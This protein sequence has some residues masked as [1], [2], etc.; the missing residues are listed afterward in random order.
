[1]ALSKT[2]NN[3]VYSIPQ[4]GE[5]GWATLT[6][7]LAALAD[8]AQTTNKQIVGRR[9]VTATPATVVATTDCYIGVN[10]LNA[11]SVVNLPAGVN[12]QVFIISDES[13]AAGTYNITITPNGLNTI[14]GGASFVLNQNKQTIYILYSG[15]NWVILH[16]S[17]DVSPISSVTDSS[18]ID[19]TVTAGV[20][21]ATIVAGSL[22]NADVNASAAIAYSKLN[23]AD[24]IVNADINS[25]AAIAYAKLNLAGGIVNADINAAAAIAYSKL[26]LAGSIVN[27]DI[28]ASAAIVYSKLSLTDS[29]L[30]ADI[31]SAAAIART[32]IANGT[33]DHVIINDGSGTLSSS[34][35]LASTK[36]GTG[37][38]NAGTLTYGSNN[39]TITT[40]GATTITSPTSGTLATLAGTEDLSNKSFTNATVIKAANELRF[41]NAA[42]TFYTAILA[43][44][45]AANRTIKLPITAPA[46]GNALV[47]TDTNGTLDWASPSSA[48][49]TTTTAGSITREGVWTAY[50]P[51]ITGFGTVTNLTVFWKIL[52]DSLMIRGFATTGT[53][54]AALASIT[55]PG[56][57]TMDTAKVRANASGASGFMV[58]HHGIQA[59]ADTSGYMVTATTTSS[60]VVYWAGA[61]NGVNSL[62]AQN[63]NALYGVSKDFSFQFEIPL[64]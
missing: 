34:A 45:N 14:N 53:P 38:N 2:W 56:G 44:N 12:G 26:N 61:I 27:A 22:V 21:T 20:L 33:A 24:S 36:G 58:G 17:T 35:Q 47:S 16:N 31:N 30:N 25:A 23:L 51:T 64:A 57:F 8:S 6:N 32:K 60:T 7:F 49:A 54:T 40:S 13:N 39:I 19:L 15:G 28:N 52:G 43:G 10:V 9:V 37:V 11:A 1:M 18:K 46:I 55:F 42:D 50:T 4:S 59:A 62:T 3:T 48:A 41:N 29:I 63:G 5:R